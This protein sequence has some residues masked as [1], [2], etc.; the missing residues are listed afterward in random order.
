MKEEKFILS[1][2]H[3]IR[4]RVNSKSFLLL[5]PKCP[6]LFLRSTAVIVSSVF[7]TLS[8]SVSD[9]DMA[10]DLLAGIVEHYFF[11]AQMIPYSTNYSIICFDRFTMIP[12]AS[13]QQKRNLYHSISCVLVLSLY[14]FNLF[15]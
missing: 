4:N 3:S 1:L 9:V 7:Q 6:I 13:C 8:M 11:K 12:W 2:N 5:C 14:A 15:N 10:L